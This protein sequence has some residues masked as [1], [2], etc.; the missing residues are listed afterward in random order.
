V[1]LILNN[2][3]HLPRVLADT[4]VSISIILEACTSGTFIN[5]DDHNATTWSKMGGKW[6]VLLI[7][8]PPEFNLKK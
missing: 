6:D 7:F 1:S 3:E 8:S 2:E 5:I 4:G